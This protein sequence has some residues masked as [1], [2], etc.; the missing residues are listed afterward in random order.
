MVCLKC[1]GISPKGN[2]LSAA[3]A[4]LAAD[5]LG[6]PLPIVKGFTVCDEV[7]YD[8]IV[9]RR[10]L[11]V[12]QVAS[13]GSRLNQKSAGTTECRNNSPSHSPSRPN[14]VWIFTHEGYESKALPGQSK[15]GNLKLPPYTSQN[16]AEQL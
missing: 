3:A 11:R 6:R 14:P 12:E 15:R 8:A 10:Q 2:L 16:M 1:A 9:L 5:L 13:E 4:F 7:V